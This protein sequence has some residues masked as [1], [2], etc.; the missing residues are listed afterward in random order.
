[1]LTVASHHRAAVSVGRFEHSDRRLTR[2]G[3]ASRR[4]ARARTRSFLTSL[5]RK[6][7]TGQHLSSWSA[8]RRHLAR[9]IQPPSGS[10]S[11]S[12]NLVPQ[13]SMASL[14]TP[15][16]SWP[17]KACSARR[18]RHSSARQTASVPQRR[19]AHPFCNSKKCRGSRRQVNRIM[20]HHDASRQAV[21]PLCHPSVA[22]PS[23]Q[24]LRS[25]PAALTLI[26]IVI[27]AAGRQQTR[28]RLASCASETTRRSSP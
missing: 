11:S 8:S 24:L 5:G 9:R 13:A 16:Q 23:L 12:R 14:A 15:S 20:N 27:M 3:H 2:F 4:C 10:C 28:L 17:D 21:Q 6:R 1:M 22:T 26:V 7:A 19:T 25:S 18:G